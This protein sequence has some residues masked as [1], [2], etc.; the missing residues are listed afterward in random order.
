MSAR[1]SRCRRSRGQGLVE[2][3]LAAP[4]FLVALLALIEGSYFVFSLSSLDRAVQEGGR[5]AAL[6]P[7]PTGSG[8][9]QR[10]DVQNRVRDGAIALS[11]TPSDV[12][13][14]VSSG[15][16][17]CETDSCFASREPGDKVRVWLSHSH[18]PLTAV[19]FGGAATVPLSFETE[20]VVE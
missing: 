10:S 1:R 12:D 16:S 2:F 17:W 18:R 7:P 9:A 19:L 3:A 4:I 11:V 6:V 13:I 15:S 8:A 20:Y 5:H 14:A